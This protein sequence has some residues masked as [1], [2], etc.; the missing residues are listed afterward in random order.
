MGILRCFYG[1][2]KCFGFFMFPLPCLLFF[3]CA[4][5]VFVRAVSSAPSRNYILPL[6]LSAP[7]CTNGVYAAWAKSITECVISSPT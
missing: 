1:E 5:N 7:V 4:N 3:S 6:P 2:T